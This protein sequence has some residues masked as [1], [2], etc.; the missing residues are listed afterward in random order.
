MMIRNGILQHFVL[1]HQHFEF[2][3]DA[4]DAIKKLHHTELEGNKLSVEVGHLMSSVSRMSVI[5][6]HLT[7]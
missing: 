1:I 7:C 5:D 3:E 2:E 4:V 6:M